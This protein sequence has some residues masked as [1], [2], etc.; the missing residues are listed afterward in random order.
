MDENAKKLNLMRYWLVGAFI[1]ILAAVTVYLVAALGLGAPILQE[2]NYWLAWLIVAV[3]F[4]AAYY[5]Y[6]WYINR[7]A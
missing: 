2:I 3:L 1:I 7:Q 4:V 6:K 5:V